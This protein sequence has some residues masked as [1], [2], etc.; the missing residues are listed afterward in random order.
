M[1]P[2]INT[3]NIRIQFYGYMIFTAYTDEGKLITD[4]D[5]RKI[6]VMNIKKNFRQKENLCFITC[7]FHSDLPC[8]CVSQD[9]P[10]Q[11]SCLESDETSNM[12]AGEKY[13]YTILYRI[14]PRFTDLMGKGILV[15]D[16]NDFDWSPEKINSITT[17][18][19]PNVPE[20]EKLEKP[21]SGDPGIVLY[22]SCGYK[23]WKSELI[24]PGKYTMDQLSYYGVKEDVSTYKVFGNVKVKLYLKSNFDNPISVDTKD[25]YI[26]GPIPCFTEYKKLNDNLQAIEII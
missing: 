14:N 8:G 1:K 4:N 19:E 3:T 20:S 12:S 6:G 22:Q 15:T 17:L 2:N 21:Y 16:Y 18:E 5:I 9:T 10:Y 13:S 25:G 7:P 26:T 24:P 11:S 23:G